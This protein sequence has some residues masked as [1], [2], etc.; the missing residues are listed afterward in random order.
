VSD[1]PALATRAATSHDL[2][3]IMAVQEQN[4]PRWG[5]VLSVRFSRDWFARAAEAGWVLVAQLGAH[6]AGYV[7]FTP[8]EAQEHVAV[9]QDMLRSHPSPGA[10]LHGPI[11]VAQQDRRK[12]VA[13][14]L[15]RAEREAMGHAP[16]VAFIRADNGASREA[17]AGMGMREVA[18]FDSAG[19]RYVVVAA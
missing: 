18:E 11:C 1:V 6:V 3:A 7:V 17:H 19:V 10:Y 4:Q 13:A 8:P 12:G 5:G 9:I 14:A 15:F 2:E 16:V